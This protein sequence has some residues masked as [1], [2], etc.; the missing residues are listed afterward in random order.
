M[1]SKVSIIIPVYNTDKYIYECLE[2]VLNQSYRFLEIIIVDDGSTD[3]SGDIIKTFLDD[4][5]IYIKQENL[6]Q[7]AARNAGLDISSG[8]FI[9]FID[10]DDVVEL[11]YI[12]IL[13][14]TFN[15]YAADVVY[16]SSDFFVDDEVDEPQINPGILQH[17]LYDELID[18]KELM[19]KGVAAKRFP[20]A[21]TMYAFKRCVL[22]GIRF[23]EGIIYED[24]L[25]IVEALFSGA[26][27]AYGLDLRGYKRRERSNSTMTKKKGLKNFDSYM[28]VSEALIALAKIHKEDII[29]IFASRL[30]VLAYKVMLESD[31]DYIS[32]RKCKRLHF[33][34]IKNNPKLVSLRLLAVV[35]FGKIYIKIVPFLKKVIVKGF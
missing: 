2:S 22:D 20:V 6:G 24:N 31:L 32:K 27:N 28:K 21:P 13:V 15:R 10:S 19:K 14:S 8:D 26:N 7:S 3:C 1:E 30:V 16:T 17:S 23:P 4:R 25:F 29:Y 11:N 33:E 18:T 5:I 9:V 35:V 34:L 12:S